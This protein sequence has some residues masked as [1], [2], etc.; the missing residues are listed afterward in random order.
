MIA[1]IS[2]FKINEITRSN[3]V[4]LGHYLAKPLH[5]QLCS[6]ERFHLASFRGS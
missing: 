4:N 5:A 2:R 3:L 1:E 6:R